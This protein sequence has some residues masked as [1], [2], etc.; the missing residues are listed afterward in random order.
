MVTG[1]QVRQSEMNTRVKRG[2]VKYKLM[3]ERLNTNDKKPQAA[4]GVHVP[5]GKIR[6]GEKTGK[7]RRDENF[8]K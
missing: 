1:G 2:R 5:V 3:V 4:C 6:G 7:G 8:K